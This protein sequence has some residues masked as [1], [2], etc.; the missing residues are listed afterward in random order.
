LLFLTSLLFSRKGR[1]GVDL[2]G[3]GGGRWGEKDFISQNTRKT[4]SKELFQKWIYKEV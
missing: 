4:V 1:R 2:D 3:M